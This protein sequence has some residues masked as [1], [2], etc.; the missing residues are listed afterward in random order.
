MC[1][2]LKAQK[3]RTFNSAL[4]KQTYVGHYAKP[5]YSLIGPGHIQNGLMIDDDQ[6][7]IDEE[8]DEEVIPHVLVC[9]SS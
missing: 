8:A 6:A 1:L 4:T 2:T 3:H 7:G 9:C 5:V